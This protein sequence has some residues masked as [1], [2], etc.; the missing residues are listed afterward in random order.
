MTDLATSEPTGDLDSQSLE[1]IDPTLE[2]GGDPKPT[3]DGS[4]PKAGR[5]DQRPP[6]RER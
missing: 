6:R 4:D 2:Q 5:G 1:P 3:S